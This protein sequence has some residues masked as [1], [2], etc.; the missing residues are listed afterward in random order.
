MNDLGYNVRELR[1][2]RY[3]DSV[4]LFIDS[5]WMFFIEHYEFFKRH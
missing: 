5:E 2:K 3:A 4:L 1:N